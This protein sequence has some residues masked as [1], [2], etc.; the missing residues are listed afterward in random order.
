[1]RA[2]PVYLTRS[3]WSQGYQI[4]NAGSNMEVGKF[5]YYRVRVDELSW[6]TSIYMLSNTFSKDGYSYPDQGVPVRCVA[7]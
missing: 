4:Y 5:G 1:M 7:R 6:I 3:G 2:A